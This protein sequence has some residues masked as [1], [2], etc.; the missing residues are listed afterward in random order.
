MD[1]TL[2]GRRAIV[3]GST[4]GI[5]RAVATALARDGASV[6]LAARHAEAMSAFGNGDVYVE[7]LLPAAR[8]V[9]VQVIGDGT[10]VSHVWERECSVQRQRQK[11]IEIAP[12]PALLSQS[13]T[14]SWS[15][16]RSCSTRNTWKTRS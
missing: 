9:E 5:G 15:S 12:A 11:L 16:W 6:T 3:C 14:G 13:R 10:E 2:R 7:Q 8:H 4:Q 1:G